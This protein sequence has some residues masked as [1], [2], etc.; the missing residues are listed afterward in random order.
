VHCTKGAIFAARD[1]LGASA[2]ITDVAALLRCAPRT[3]VRRLT[4]QELHE[5]ALARRTRTPETIVERAIKR[6]RIAESRLG[7]LPMAR[8]S[9]I[10]STVMT[11]C[12]GYNEIVKAAGLIPRPAWG[13][14]VTRRC[15]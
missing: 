4:K 12:G 9:G 2:T 8:E 10:H 5:W 13:Y 7:R 14:A 1:R 3:V 15:Q 11:L 6:L